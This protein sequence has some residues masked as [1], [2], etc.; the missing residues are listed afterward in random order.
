MKHF[1]ATLIVNNGRFDRKRVLPVKASNI[2]AAFGHAARE[3]RKVVPTRQH[4]AW[5]SIRIEQLRLVN[6]DKLTEDHT[7]DP[8]PCGDADCSRPFGHEVEA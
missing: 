8:C 7:D 1:S 6:L 4:V 2:R 5:A 3:I